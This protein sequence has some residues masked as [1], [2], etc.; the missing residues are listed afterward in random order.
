MTQEMVG[1][2]GNMKIIFGIGCIAHQGQ[3]ITSMAQVIMHIME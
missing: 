2:K 1:A 3:E